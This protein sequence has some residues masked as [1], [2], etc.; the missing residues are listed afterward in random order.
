MTRSHALL[1][2]PAVLSSVVA[3]VCRHLHPD[4]H[5]LVAL[6]QHLTLDVPHTRLRGLP[7]EVIR[8]EGWLVDQRACLGGHDAGGDGVQVDSHKVGVLPC[9]VQALVA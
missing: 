9:E 7:E 5:A 1:H 2:T 4:E 8:A 6:R 3:A